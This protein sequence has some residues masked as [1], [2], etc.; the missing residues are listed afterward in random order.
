MNKRKVRT[1]EKTSK[2]LKLHLL[3]SGILLIMSFVILFA[4]PAVGVVLMAIAV[5]W[6]LITKILI[7]WN[8]G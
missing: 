4:Q 6:H 3:L 2:P 7:W 1:I 8:H 5:T